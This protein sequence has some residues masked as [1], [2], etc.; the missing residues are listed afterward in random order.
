LSGYIFLFKLVNVQWNEFNE[1]ITLFADGS[2][3]L[4]AGF[5]VT[6]ALISNVA[7]NELRLLGGLNYAF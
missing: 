4:K 2:Y 3:P 6:A 7:N 5:S 1:R